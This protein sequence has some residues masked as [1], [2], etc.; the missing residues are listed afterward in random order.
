MSLFVS[1]AVYATEKHSAPLVSIPTHDRFFDLI[2][3]H[4]GQSFK[5]KVV[6]DNEPSQAFDQP[7]LMHVRTCKPHELQIPFHVGNNASRTWIITKTGSGLTLKHDHRNPDGSDDTLTMYGGQTLNAGYDNM[8]SFPADEYSKQLFVREGMPQS[9]DNTW[10][11]FVYPNTF[12]YQ[13]VRQ[14]RVF[15]V[16]FDLTQP[17]STPVT[18]WGY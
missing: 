11:V 3:A 13:L 2:S 1:G 18:P 16:E 17:V 15:R 4:C 9:V 7:L 10:E 6:V 8:Q 5:G 14:G 12:S